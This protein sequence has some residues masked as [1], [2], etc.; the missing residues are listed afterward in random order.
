MVAMFRKSG[1]FED[2]FLDVM[3]KKKRSHKKNKKDSSVY[4]A[5]T[6]PKDMPDSK[7]IL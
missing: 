4:L 5:T 7:D 3:G 1:P 6:D 2:I